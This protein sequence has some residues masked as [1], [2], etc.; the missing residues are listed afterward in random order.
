LRRQVRAARRG[1]DP[2]EREAADTA[3]LRHIRS[4]PAYRS[5]RLVALF[6]AFDG[7][8]DLGPLVRFGRRKQFFSPVIAGNDIQFARLRPNTSLIPNR[9]GIAEPYPPELIDPRAL[10]IVLTPLVAFDG[11]GNRLGVGAG[12][13]DRCFAFLLGRRIWRKPKLVGTA[14]ALQRVETMDPNPWD[15]PLWGAI[16]EHGF[17][18][19]ART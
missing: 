3:I 16:T 14:Y 9:F 10:D 18:A 7:E 15:V 5:A 8:P 12:Y 19:F 1:M 4:L 6:F 2:D 11:Q 17:E 13:Y